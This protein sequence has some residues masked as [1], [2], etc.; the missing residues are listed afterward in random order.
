MT[1]ANGKVFSANQYAESVNVFDAATFA[2]LASIK[3]GDYP[4]SVAA[5]RDR[6]IVYVTNWFSNELW[7]I[8]ARAFK[9]VGK[10]A[11]G[12]GP[13]AFGDFVRRAN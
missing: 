12:D 7:A 1:L 8:D 3:A 2:P 13:R 6:A 11:T 10:V 5:S 9:V 4:E